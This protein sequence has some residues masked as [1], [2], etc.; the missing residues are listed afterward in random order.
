MRP[1]RG[2]ERQFLQDEIDEI[3]R[4]SWKSNALQAELLDRFLPVLRRLS[5]PV[6]LTPELVEHLTI[7]VQG[8][9]RV[10]WV[11][12]G[13][14]R[15][16]A[17]V[18]LVGI[19]P[20]RYQAERALWAFRDA[21]VDGLDLEDAVNQSIGS[22]RLRASAARFA[23]TWLRCLIVSVFKSPWAWPRLRISFAPVKNSCI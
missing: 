8:K 1:S 23:Q 17:R 5:G 20:G 15:K 12:F 22:R 14:M 9:I 2:Q 3:A 4:V 11:P 13:Y 10:I 16:G 21:F 18:V 19:T 7:E 6:Q